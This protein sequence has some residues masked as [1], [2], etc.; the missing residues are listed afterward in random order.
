M[1]LLYLT[2]DAKWEGVG[3]GWEGRGEVH[4]GEKYESNGQENR[5]RDYMSFL[6]L[7][8]NKDV[9]TEGYGTYFAMNYM[10]LWIV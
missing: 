1:Q 7:F 10:K 8:F 9:L 4:L 3:G 6:Q 2:L 5:L